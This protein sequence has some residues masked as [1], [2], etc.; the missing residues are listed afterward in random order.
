MKHLLK[1]FWIVAVVLTVFFFLASQ[2]LLASQKFKLKQAESDGDWLTVK[3]KDEDWSASSPTLTVKVKVKE[4]KIKL[5]TSSG[6]YV[7]K[8]KGEKTKIYN[9]DE[10]LRFVIKKTAEKIKVLQSDDDP[11]PW[12]LKVKDNNQ[13][14]KVSKGEKEIGKIKFYPDISKM[15]VKDHDDVEVCDMKMDKLLPGPAVCL[16]SG[17]SEEDKLLLFTVLIIEYH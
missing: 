8:L 5:T 11:N 12:S 4:G 15:K 3:L 14:Y 10:S 13:R 6:E 17:L 16:F 1:R 2:E 9:P 7:A